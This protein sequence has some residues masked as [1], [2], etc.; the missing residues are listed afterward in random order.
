MLCRITSIVR[1]KQRGNACRDNRNIDHCGEKWRSGCRNNNNFSG[2]SD[3]KDHD[4]HRT[5]CARLQG[6]RQETLRARLSTI[7]SGRDERVSTWVGNSSVH[8]GPGNTTLRCHR[9]DVVL[10]SVHKLAA[11]APGLTASAPPAIGAVH[12]PPFRRCLTTRTCSRDPDVCLSLI[13]PAFDR[14]F[15]GKEGTTHHHLQNRPPESSMNH[16]Q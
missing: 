16:P 11:C 8:Q 3:G 13:M 12:S 10:C 14:V 4:R 9:P 1:V 2:D 6:C 5:S 7:A 15:P